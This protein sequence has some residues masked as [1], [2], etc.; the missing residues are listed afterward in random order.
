[1]NTIAMYIHYGQIGTQAALQKLKEHQIGQVIA[2]LG[3]DVEHCT[4][5]TEHELFAYLGDN[6]LQVAAAYVPNDQ[7]AYLRNTRYGRKDAL[8]A[9][10]QY[11]LSAVDLHVPLLILDGAPT[12]DAFVD[13]LTEIC[14]YAAEQ[15][16]MVALRDGADVDTI[17]LLS[18]VNNLYY[19]LD[20]ATCIKQHL[21]PVARI[22]ALSSRLMFTVLSDLDHE[23]TRLLPTEGHT[24][25]API[26]TTLRASGYTGIYGIYA[27]TCGA[28]DVD[29]F[30]E[31]AK[32]IG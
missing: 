4:T 26:L 13:A 23:D 14:D 18:R 10:K 1:M 29:A 2:W 3:H 9:Y 21:D 6:G 19:C 5:L 25:F 11:V 28:Q 27:T 31:T 22:N 7:L 32:S 17:G 8:K 20:T 16:I 12:S 30:L 15:G 24:D